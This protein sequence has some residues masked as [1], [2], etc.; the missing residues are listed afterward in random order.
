MIHIE[1]DGNTMK[2]RPRGTG[3]VRGDSGAFEVGS[4]V[5]KSLLYV[6]SLLCI[7]SLLYK[8]CLTVPFAL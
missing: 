4:E 6:K 1:T 8:P 7:K 3:G 5:C 2:D